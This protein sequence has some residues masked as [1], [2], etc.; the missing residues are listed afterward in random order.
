MQAIPLTE[1]WKDVW[2]MVVNNSDQAWMSHSYDWIVKVSENVWKY[3]SLSFLIEDDNKEIVGIFPIFL[4]DNR[5]FRFVSLKVLCSGWGANGLAVINGLGNKHR[6]AVEQFAYKHVDELAKKFAVDK[7]EIRLPPLAPAYLPPMS[8][9]INPLL[10]HGLLDNSSATFLIDLK[11]NTI[12]D[13]WKRM[14][15]RSRTAIRKAEKKGVK[16]RKITDS[17][18]IKKHYYR[19]HYKTYT[20]TGAIPHPLAFF[21]TI[22]DNGFANIFFAEYEENV[23][24]ALNVATFKIGA[25]YW[26]SAS[27]YKYRALNSNNLLQW[28][29]IKWAKEHGYEWYESGE[30]CLGV[31]DPKLKGLTRFKG[32]FGGMLLPYYK[33]LKIYKPLKESFFNL[34][35]KIKQKSN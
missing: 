18:E 32:S 11:N 4:R 7:L 15:G 3:K 13:L 27:D 8:P 12:K 6:N 10:F 22:Y 21:T 33:G 26:T 24:A 23:I 19:L 20:R 31:D 34:L 1:D 9:R 16:I 14:D 17:N 28:H 2:D 35:K 5:V 25:L 29:A 30:A